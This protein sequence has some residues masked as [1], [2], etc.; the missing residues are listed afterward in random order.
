MPDWVLIKRDFS[1][2]R[3]GLLLGSGP[4][5]ALYLYN[6]AIAQPLSG[7]LSPRIKPGQVPDTNAIIEMPRKPKNRKKLRTGRRASRDSRNGLRGRKQS[8]R[9]EARRKQ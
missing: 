6:R 7:G 3:D 4:L 5:P 2:G 8:I 9:R 1:V